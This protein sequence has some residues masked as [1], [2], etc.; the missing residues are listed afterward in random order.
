M[1]IDRQRLEGHALEAATHTARHQALRAR[2]AVYCLRR[3][4]AVTIYN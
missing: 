3:S 2:K 4:Y 1:E